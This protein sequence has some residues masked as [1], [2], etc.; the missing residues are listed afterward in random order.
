MNSECEIL[1]FHSFKYLN[2]IVIRS[3]WL[4][5]ENK[6]SAP[7]DITHKLSCILEKK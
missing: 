1:K 3:L 2:I 4:R 5:M 7:A 6:S